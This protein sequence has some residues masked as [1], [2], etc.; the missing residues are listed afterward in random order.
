MQC[1]VNNINNGHLFDEPSITSQVSKSLACSETID[2]AS[3][4]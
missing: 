4:D 1:G 2:R 3:V